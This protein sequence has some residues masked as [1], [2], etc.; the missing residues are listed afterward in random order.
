MLM[1]L[2]PTTPLLTAGHCSTQTPHPVQSSG[3]T[4]MVTR[5]GV[6]RSLDLKGLVT[7]VSG[8]PS[9]FSG[10]RTFIPI[11]L[12]GHTIA[13][14]PQSIQTSASQIGIS[15]AIARFSY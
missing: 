1:A 10:G 7:N 3:E 15:V 13:H 8:A 12:W 5:C 9:A 4:W 2:W 11:A 14:L 6:A